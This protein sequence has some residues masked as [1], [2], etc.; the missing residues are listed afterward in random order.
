MILI[1]T[2]SEVSVALEAHQRL[3]K[4]RHSQPCRLDALVGAV[5]PSAAVIP[6]RGSSAERSCP[7]EHRGGIVF[8]MGTGP[9]VPTVQSSASLVL[10]RRR[11]G[12]T[13]MHEFGFT[14]ENVAETARRQFS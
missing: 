6:R 9:S 7:S 4:R 3:T 5:R 2:G 8:R 1:A 14:P 13:L 11:P 10:E 12:P